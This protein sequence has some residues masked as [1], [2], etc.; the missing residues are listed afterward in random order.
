LLSNVL[1]LGTGSSVDN[2]YGFL[3]STFLIRCEPSQLPCKSKWSVEGSKF[4]ANVSKGIGDRHSVHK[5]LC[6]GGVQVTCV[7]TQDEVEKLG[8]L[9]IK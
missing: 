9:A 8:D 4:S 6:S 7:D 2:C 5:E 3:V 1:C